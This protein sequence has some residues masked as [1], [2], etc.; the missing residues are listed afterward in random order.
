MLAMKVIDKV[1]CTGKEEMVE[2]EVRLLRQ[3]NHEVGILRH[4]LIRANRL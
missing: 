4:F 1:K 3:T 2:S